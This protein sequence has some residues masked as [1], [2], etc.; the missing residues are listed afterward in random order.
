MISL[1]DGNPNQLTPGYKVRHTSN[2]YM[3]LK[4]GTPYILG[5][6][7][8][9][10]NQSQIQV[11]QFINII[12]FGFSAQETVERAR[13]TTTAFP[14]GTYPYGVDNTLN[15]QNGFPVELRDEL[16]SRGHTINIGGTF[17]SANIIIIEDNG[18]SAQVG[19]EPAVDTS[20]GIVN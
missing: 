10:D 17:G 12:E 16:T 3:V 2:P 1:E 20:Y 15:M 8:G 11:Q 7:T 9:A 5:G 6:N 18:L 4:N 13:F 19:P 14:A